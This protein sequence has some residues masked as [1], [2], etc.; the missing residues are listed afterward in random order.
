[1]LV[2]VLN[3]NCIII[4]LLSLYPYCTYFPLLR[5]ISGVLPRKKNKKNEHLCSLNF[6]LSLLEEFTIKRKKISLPFKTH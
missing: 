3:N 2:R 1:M 5:S 6:R 4:M